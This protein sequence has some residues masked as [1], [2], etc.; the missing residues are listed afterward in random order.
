MAWILAT[1]PNPEVRNASQAIEL[2]ERAA[3]LTKYQ[4]AS[5]LDTLAAAYAA[6]GQF[7]RAATTAQTAIALASTAEDDELVNHIRK[8]LEL[9]KQTRPYR[10]PVRSQ[11][12]VRP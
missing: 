7:D 2:A 12:A 6:A 3:E 1:H 11:D 9:Y 10:E 5:V 8:R 4:N